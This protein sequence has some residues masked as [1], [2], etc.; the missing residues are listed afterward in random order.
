MSHVIHHPRVVR[1]SGRAAWLLYQAA[2]RDLRRHEHA[3]TP[4]ASI[5]YLHAWWATEEVEAA[6]ADAYEREQRA[7]DALP[8]PWARFCRWWH[9]AAYTVALLVLVLLACFAWRR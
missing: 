1:I 2:M 9:G 3:G 5:G 4:A 6:I 8:S 7:L